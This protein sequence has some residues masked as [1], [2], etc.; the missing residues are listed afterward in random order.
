MSADL[1]AEFGVGSTSTQSSNQS[2]QQK[3]RSQ[4]NL[5]IPDLETTDDSLSANAWG[6]PNASTIRTTQQ[7]SYSGNSPAFQP[8]YLG[9]S[10]HRPQKYD[11]N[12][13]FDSSLET[14]SNNDS[15]EWGEFESAEA[16]SQS[17]PTKT[18]REA[19]PQSG[20]ADLS[21]GF[22]TF[23]G[24]LNLIDSSIE[25]SAP[26]ARGAPTVTPA[27]NA[28]SQRTQSK[29]MSHTPA[30]PLVEL[31]EPFEDWGEFIDG[32]NTTQSKSTAHTPAKLSVEPNE[33]S[34]DWG[35]FVD[36]PP[37][38]PSPQETFKGPE[39]GL[40]KVPSKN[41]DQ[42]TSPPQVRP[43]NIPPPS[44]LL[45]MFPQLFEQLRQEATTA[46]KDLQQNGIL[47]HT[48]V[49]IFY[50][51]KTAARIIAGRTLRWKRDSILS[52]S[53]KI[54]PARSGKQ[55]GMKLNTV[56]KNENIK[57]QQEALDILGIWRDRTALFNSVLQASGKRPI[58]VIA[59]NTRVMTATADQGALKAPH[60][61]ALCGLKR[62][63]RLPK[64]DERVEDSF[65]EWWVD[66]W[67]HTDCKHFWETNM[68]LL[69]QR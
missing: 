34:E 15:E 44:V 52:Q 1:F 57:E 41:M 47:E 12:V 45:Q 68:R 27:G 66:H 5:L 16:P 26:P 48:A 19:V 55:G 42:H 13:L 8:N 7:K 49:Q 22:S 31:D 38:K 56:N 63:E 3:S 20:N 33:P 4:A 25:D 18:S 6:N 40:S 23:S 28:Q 64:V 61:C 51:I 65:G 2:H 37:I 32:P 36:G 58:P 69:G 17:Q 30:R 9:N 46:K 24:P 35:E 43:T 10:G 62:D 60:P 14:A 54:G 39:R 11:D 53:M 67:G 21:K 50:T 59:E 29:S